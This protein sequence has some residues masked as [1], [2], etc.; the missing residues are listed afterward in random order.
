[1]SA[2]AIG[3]R[4][5]RSAGQDPGVY[6]KLVLIYTNDV[7]KRL[8]DIDD[9]ALEAARVELGTAT[10]KDTVNES[11]RRAAGTREAAVTDALDVLS[12]VPLADRS[13]AWS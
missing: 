4:E 7:S 1:V 8:V 6:T 13:D 3:V 5:C 9:D 11:L 10:I 12:G 2:I